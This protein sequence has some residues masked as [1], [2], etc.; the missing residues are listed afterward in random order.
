MR[1]SGETIILSCI[2]AET[3]VITLQNLST[4]QGAKETAPCQ[5]WLNLWGP[6]PWPSAELVE[7]QFQLGQSENLSMTTAIAD[8]FM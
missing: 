3:E 6:G 4:N 8:C 2:F 7:N 5:I 1:N